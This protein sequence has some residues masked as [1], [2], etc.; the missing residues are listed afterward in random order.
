MARTH[1]DPS[2]DEG[3]TDRPLGPEIQRIDEKPADDDVLVYNGR[4]GVY[5]GH[6]SSVIHDLSSERQQ[7]IAMRTMSLT[8]GLNY[9]SRELWGKLVAATENAPTGL[10]ARLAAGEIV[11]VRSFGHV[12]IPQATEWVR[13]TAAVDA[14][15]R[16]RDTEERDKVLEAIDRQIRLATNDEA[17][18]RPIGRRA[19]A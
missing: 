7:R 19:T 16:L 10:A 17:P 11:E 5:Q 9:V 14:L 1:R 15:K 8:P 6:L 4:S 2:P 3:S 12:S 13:H 18:S